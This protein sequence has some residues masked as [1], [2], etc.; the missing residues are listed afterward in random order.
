MT[1][2]QKKNS[3]ANAG[4][5]REVG[6][7]HGS[8]R[9]HE[10]GNGNILQYSCLKN[11]MDRGAWQS[12]VHG[13]AKSRHKCAFFINFVAILYDHDYVFT[14]ID[15]VLF[16]EIKKMNASLVPLLYLLFHSFKS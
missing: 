12:K 8:G 5:E 2:W 16:N 4:D 13:V 11:S 3:S 7:I 15:N 14:F 6:L 10:E 9:S 1:Q